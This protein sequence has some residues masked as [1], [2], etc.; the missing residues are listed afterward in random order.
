[1]TALILDTIILYH[2]LDMYPVDLYVCSKETWLIIMWI[3]YDSGEC[4]AN[5]N[6]LSLNCAII[7]YN[8]LYR[9]MKID[10]T[11]WSH[12]K[13]EKGDKNQYKRG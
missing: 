1:M 12:I 7:S 5:T 4:D 10:I 9:C 11:T 6:N 8:L 3:V 2:M 13:V